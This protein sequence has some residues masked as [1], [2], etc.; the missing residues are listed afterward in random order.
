VSGDPGKVALGADAASLGAVGV[1]NHSI[2]GPAV[3]ARHFDQWW[4]W[5]LRGIAE[6]VGHV[7][8]RVQ[9]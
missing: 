5:Q 4:E 7:L 6:R 9:M 8:Q 1:D 2:L 3:G